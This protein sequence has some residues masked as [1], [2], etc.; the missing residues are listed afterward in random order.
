[1]DSK[2]HAETTSWPEVVDL[3][4]ELIV[5]NQ[6]DFNHFLQKF[7]KIISNIISIDSCLI[8]FYD[9]DKKQLILIASKKPHKDQIGKISMEVGEGITGWVAQHKQ[10]VAIEKE[11]YKDTRFKPFKELPEDKYESFLSVP[12]TNKT[13]IIGVINLQNRTPATFSDDT[14]KIVESLVKIIASGFAKVVLERKVST[15]ENQLEERKVIEKA[16][17][18]IMKQKAVSE[19]EAYQFLRHEAMKKRK[20]LREI[21]DA[22]ILIFQ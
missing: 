22:V 11:A 19:N 14:I 4:S 7:I 10:T 5:F 3:L 15:L 21:A 18:I 9:K 12:I 2:K 8:Y 6:Y 13:G 1:M 17:G 20:S 16:K